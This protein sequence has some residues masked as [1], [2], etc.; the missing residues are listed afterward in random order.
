[1]RTAAVLP[2]KRFSRAKQ[3]L[4]ESVAD[5]LR[6]ALAGAMVADVLHA[7]PRTASLACT[8]VVTGEESVAGAARALGAIVVEDEAESSQSAAAALGVERAL[9]EGVRARAVRARRLPR[10][11]S[12]RA[13]G[14][15]RRAPAGHGGGDRP[16]PPRQRHQRAA[17]RA[18]RPRSRRASGRTAASATSRSPAPPARP[19]RVERPPSLL[20]DIDTGADLDALRERLAGTDARA[21]R[22]RA[23]LA[24]SERTDLLT[25]SARA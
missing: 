1:M 17:A 12:R 24:R 15:A 2:V 19:A 23:V 6:M 7:L 21:A 8:I 4:G 3:R 18:R 10:A 25:L 14:A 5:Q 20:L 16:R 22:T 11:R 13:A 9:A